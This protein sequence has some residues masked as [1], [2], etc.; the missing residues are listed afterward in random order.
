MSAS[1]PVTPTSANNPLTS[2]S[3][4]YIHSFVLGLAFPPKANNA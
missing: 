2:A 4:N 1:D 3:P